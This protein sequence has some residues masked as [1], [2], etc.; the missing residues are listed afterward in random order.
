MQKLVLQYD[1]CVPHEAFGTETIPF[2]YESLESAYVDFW[3]LQENAEYFFSFLGREF[4]KD[5][6]A[7]IFTLEEWFET[8]KIN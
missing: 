7:K 8:Y 3:T 5:V 2:E 1:W 6:D 4:E